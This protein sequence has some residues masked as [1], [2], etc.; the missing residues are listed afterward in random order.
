MNS[1]LI[2]KSLNR[3]LEL[4]LKRQIFKESY[5]EFFKWSFNILFPNE[6]YEDTFH[7]KFLC[8]LYQS[9]VERIIR[10]EEKSKDIIANI[11]PRA[12]KS[13]ITSVSLLAWMWILEPSLP[14]ISI[15]FDEDLSLVNAQY[16]KDIIKSSE[17]QE[18]F[19]DLYQIRNDADSK[20]YFMND[21]GGFRLS[22]T[23]GSNITG[24]KGVVIVVDD[25][26]NPKT[27]ES[28][29]A[30]KATIDY[31][32]KSL[33]NRLTP[34][35]LGIRIIIMQRLHENDLTGYLLDN[36]PDQYVHVCLPAQVS[37]KVKPTHLKK[38]YKDGL[39]DPIRLSGS[40][41]QG[42]L[43]TLGTRAYTGQYKQ[44]P[45]PE[46]G[47]II[48]KGWFDILLPEM[49]IRNTVESPIHFFIDS[50]YT[51]KTENDPTGILSCFIQD[52][53]LYILDFKEWWLEFPE[54]CKNIIIHTNTYQYT[55]GS[56]IFVEPKA[57][58]KSIV[59]QLRSTTQL[60]MIE[61]PNPENDKTTRAHSIT[62]ILESRRV[63][64]IR[65]PYID[66]FLDLLGSFPSGNHD[67]AVDVLVMAVRELL[68][69]NSPDFCF[70]QIS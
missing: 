56:K 49:I 45:S 68:I 5:F 50:A 17:Y 4:E 13:L 3:E 57:S 6:K 64:L 66:H 22:K 9:E 47:S 37:D 52:N 15:S 43:K 8:D 32:T 11:P 40:I 18:L 34:I 42:F 24:H 55:S 21:K 35:N 31:Y 33:Y 28:E 58:G 16:S 12:S 70:L 1:E 59:Q 65:G 39:L 23:T 48:R 46:E 53:Y 69:D 2:H 7:V 44:A 63:R 62:A 26:Q 20:S 41:L 14:M 60:N 54:L 38:E 51:N 30:R 19:G 61:A 36:D 29:I 27:S 25:P 10:K 67:E